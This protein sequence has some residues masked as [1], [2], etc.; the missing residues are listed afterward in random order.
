VAKVLT[1][2]L[3]VLT[4]NSPPNLPPEKSGTP[5]YPA[6]RGPTLDA[7]VEI[8]LQTLRRS[9]PRSLRMGHASRSMASG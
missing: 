7:E 8:E 6:E 5:N 3:T 2:V 4:Q 1:Q 9:S